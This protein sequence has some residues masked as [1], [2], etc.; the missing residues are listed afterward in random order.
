MLSPTAIDIGIYFF[1]IFFI[2]SIR[3]QAE[4][5]LEHVPNSIILQLYQ[6][7]ITTLK[8]TEKHMYYYNIFLTS[9]CTHVCVCVLKNLSV[10]LHHV[11]RFY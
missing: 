11:I 3:M 4:A 7:H 10:M 8:L 5:N 9:V 2:F 1:S 6:T